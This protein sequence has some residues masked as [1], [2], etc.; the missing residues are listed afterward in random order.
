MTSANIEYKIKNI[1]L[2]AC[3]YN[4]N[5]IENKKTTGHL[6]VY[7]SQCVC[8]NRWIAS[9]TLKS[10]PATANRHPW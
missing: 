9:L 7:Y 10:C 1:N 5:A 4:Q 6:H 2:H 3:L 8:E